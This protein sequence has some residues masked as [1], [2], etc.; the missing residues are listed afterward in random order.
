MEIYVIETVQTLKAIASVFTLLGWVLTVLWAVM[1]AINY[2]GLDDDT[3]PM[4]V[5]IILSIIAVVSTM[6]A[7][8][9]PSSKAVE[10]LL[11]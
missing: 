7:V 8:F 11:K 5:L 3:K 1:L 10:A 6:F 4:R 9:I 2:E